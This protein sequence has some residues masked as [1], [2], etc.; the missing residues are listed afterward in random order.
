MTR[1]YRFDGE[2]PVRDKTNLLI[3]NLQDAMEGLP[4]SLVI[5][6]TIADPVSTPGAAVDLPRG[7]RL[8]LMDEQMSWSDIAL[9]AGATRALT[10]HLITM[11]TE[12]YGD[13][14]AKASH[15]AGEMFAAAFDLKSMDLP[16]SAMAK[17]TRK[18]AREVDSGEE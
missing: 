1:I 3:R 9:L 7:I 8:F 16:E 11:Y 2:Q 4:R 12:Q 14:F 17:T 18:S 13:R 10:E 5:G 15:V 6:A